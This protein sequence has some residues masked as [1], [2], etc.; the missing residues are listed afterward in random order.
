MLD[1]MIMQVCKWDKVHGWSKQW[2]APRVRR[3]IEADPTVYVSCCFSDLCFSF[4]FLAI[5]RMYLC[6]ALRRIQNKQQEMALNERMDL[7]RREVNKRR[8]DQR[9][10]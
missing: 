2:M 6:S 5:R 4:F 8:Y 3:R 7:M 10:L 9:D 1:T